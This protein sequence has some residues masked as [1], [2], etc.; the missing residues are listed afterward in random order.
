MPHEFSHLGDGFEAQQRLREDL[1]FRSA[2]Q[3][4]VDE[5]H[6]DLAGRS[7]FRAAAVLQLVAQ[8]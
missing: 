8:G 3:D 4:L 1:L 2:A 7:R 6:G 5:A